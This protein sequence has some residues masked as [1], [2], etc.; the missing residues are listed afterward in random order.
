MMG[1]NYYRYSMNFVVGFICF[2]IFVGNGRFSSEQELPMLDLTDPFKYANIAQ[3]EI[4]IPNLTLTRD[5]RVNMVLDEVPATPSS[6][7]A[8]KILEKIGP[9]DRYIERHATNYN[10]DPDLIRAIIYAES[11]GNPT[12]VSSMG[13]EGLMQIMPFTAKF[14][15]ISDP[16]DPEDNILGGIRYLSWLASFQNN[17]N[18]VYLLWAYN[19]GQD[20]LEKCIMPEETRRFISSVLSIK[21]CL[22][23]FSKLPI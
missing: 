3:E 8:A 21:S 7:R 19:A 10:L 11:G 22:K 13:A 18:E 5:M 4:V 12:V 17:V 15:G 16:F 20:C 14:I 1:K 23:E 6:R 9:W 2:A